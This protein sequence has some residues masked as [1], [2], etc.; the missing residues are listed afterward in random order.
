M[1]SSFDLTRRDALRLGAGALAFAAVGRS[2][3]AAFSQAPA[4]PKKR[5]PNIVMLVADDH[6]HSALGS[7][8]EFALQTPVIDRLASEGTA[9]CQAHH[10]GG[11]FSAVCVPTRGSLMTGCTVFRALADQSGGVIAPNRVTLGQHLRQSGYHA[12]IV[13]K[14][15]NDRTSLTRS[16]DN[17]EAIFL[18]GLNTDQYSMRVRHFDPTGEYANKTVYHAHKFSTDFLCDKA[19]EFLDSYKKDEPF[20]LYTAFTAPHD[21]RTPPKPFDR[22]YRPE[23]IALPPNFAPNHPFDNG[24]LHV[25]D[26]DLI[27][28][29]RTPERVRREIASY[30]GMVSNLD[31]AVGGF[32]RPCA[33]AGAR[34]TPSLS[35]Q[36]TMESLTGTARSIG[37]TEPL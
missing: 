14:W 5:R 8:G 31:A 19:V 11:N 4:A 37:K 27:P 26:E 10:M 34:R 2:A 35:T 15:H 30:Y 16:F 36:P 22:M 3:R 18:R 21:P 24:E 29:P 1:T 12:H 6:R 20:F 7:M 17:G 25:R 23:N 13:G 33:R 32:W 28:H 9:F